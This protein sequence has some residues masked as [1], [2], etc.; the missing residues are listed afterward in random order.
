MLGSDVLSVRLGGIYALQRLAEDEPELYHVPIVSLFS[1]FARDPN[2]NAGKETGLNRGGRL[3]K[4][5]ESFED[6]QEAVMAIGRRS[7]SEIEL[8]KKA[9][10]SVNLIGVKLALAPLSHANLSGVHMGVADLT[11]ATLFNADLTGAMLNNIDLTGATLTEA[12]LRG[13]CLRDANLSGADLSRVKGLTQEQLDQAC[14]DPDSPPKLDGVHDA[15]TGVPL[16]WREN[17]CD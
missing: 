6:V 14:A 5:K 13:T 4:F 12:T 7:A 8:E 10:Y 1:A 16:Q 2:R 15:K 3:I 9:R 17:P 11:V